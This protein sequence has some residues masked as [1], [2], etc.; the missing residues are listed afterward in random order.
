MQLAD[1]HEQQQTANDEPC[2]RQYKS[3][4][5][6]VII[7]YVTAGCENHKET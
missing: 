2:C 5:Y 4:I 3:E 1:C 7:R 6:C